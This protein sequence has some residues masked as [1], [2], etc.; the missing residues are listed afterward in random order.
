MPPTLVGR[1]IGTFLQDLVPDAPDAIAALPFMRTRMRL[2]Q[3]L[4][5][6][7]HM[8]PEQV[9][10]APH[11]IVGP[12]DCDLSPPEMVAA[13]LGGT[14]LAPFIKRQ[15]RSRSRVRP[16]PSMGQYSRQ[17]GTARPSFCKR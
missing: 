4:L 12:K 1:L 13:Y 9:E 6:V 17:P 3:N 11:K 5:D 7:S 2:W 10:T 15:C 16:L 8:T 14:P